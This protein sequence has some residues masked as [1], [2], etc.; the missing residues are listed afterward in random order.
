MEEFREKFHE[1]ENEMHLLK[2]F[3]EQ[4]FKGIESLSCQYQERLLDRLTA[5]EQMIMKQANMK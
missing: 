3:V 4:R 1:Q 5:L 2:D